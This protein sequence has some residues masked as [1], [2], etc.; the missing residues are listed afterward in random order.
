MMKNFALKLYLVLQI[1]YS[2]PRLLGLKNCFK[3]V[4]VN[5]LYAYYI[6]DDTASIMTVLFFINVL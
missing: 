3:W 4:L 5:I 1:E 2:S 6:H